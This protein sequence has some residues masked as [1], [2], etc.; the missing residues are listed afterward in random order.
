MSFETNDSLLSNFSLIMNNEMTFLPQQFS[1]NASTSEEAEEQPMKLMDQKKQRRMISN[2]ESA[3]RSR[4]RK[5]SQI[6][7]LWAQVLW[8]EKEKH[9]LL[10]K[11][12]HVLKSHDQ[13]LQENIQLKEEACN[14]RQMLT[15][16]KLFDN[17]FHNALRDLE[18]ISYITAPRIY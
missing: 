14:L 18:S 3:R 16:M 4:L 1:C 13:V 8:L 10:Q 15:T 9:H 5:K 11:L 17:D 7:E 6:R 12:N 2:R